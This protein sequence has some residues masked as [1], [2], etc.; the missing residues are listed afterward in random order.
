MGVAKGSL[1]KIYQWFKLMEFNAF[2]AMS[3]RI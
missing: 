3:F 1:K 2:K